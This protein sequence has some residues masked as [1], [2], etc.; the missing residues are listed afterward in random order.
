MQAVDRELRVP[1]PGVLALTVEGDLYSS[2]QHRCIG[3]LVLL[4]LLVL[5]V[6]VAIG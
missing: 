6:F 2:L 3:H 5:L 4:A 1:A